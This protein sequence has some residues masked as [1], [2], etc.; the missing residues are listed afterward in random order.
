MLLAIDVGNTNTVFA[1]FDGKTLCGQWRLSTDSSRT[2]DEYAVYLL[3]L[4]ERQ[5]VSVGHISAAL[6]ASVV[7]DVN[8]AL[9]SMCRRHFKC[10]VKHIGDAGVEVPMKVR[11]DK[12]EQL[13]AD[14]LVSAYAAWQ[15][16]HKALIVVDFGT[17]TT[18]DVVDADG[19]YIGGVIAPGINLSLD[20]LQ[21]AA[22][23]LPSVA[24]AQPKKVI[25]TNTID[26]MQSGIFYGY[27]SLI[28]GILQ[29]I[30]REAAC[31]MEVIATGGLAPLYG[32]ETPLIGHVES[33]LTI[34]GLQQLHAASQ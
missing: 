22:A 4:M 1:I 13:G 12:P 14:R 16:Y 25:G 10:D 2:A 6:M 30:T 27:L 28:E 7:P 18:F 5:G 19:S 34:Y 15:R 33:D 9:L 8:H 11:I 32:R 29:R 26:A 23:K 17:A 20:A 21:H 3:Q 24:I 31:E